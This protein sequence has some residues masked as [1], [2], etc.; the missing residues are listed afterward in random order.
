MTTAGCFLRLQCP[1][2]ISINS[3]FDHYSNS[4]RRFSAELPSIGSRICLQ[5]RLTFD[6]HCYLTQA[7]VEAAIQMKNSIK[8]VD[9]RSCA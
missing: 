5:V 2:A 3:H 7:A 4:C 1:E 9:P 6:C 8:M